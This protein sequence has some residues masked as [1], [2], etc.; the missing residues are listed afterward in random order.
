MGRGP[1][2]KWEWHDLVPKEIRNNVTKQE[3]QRQAIIWELIKGEM[4][5]VK[6]LE[7][8]DTLFIRPLRES[9]IIPPDRLPS[10]LQ[11]VFHNFAE[12]HGHHRRM[13]ERLH[14]IQREEHPFIR[15]ITA[16]VF[17]AAL[18]WRDA[19]L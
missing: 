2:G 6:D 12:I 15:S 10:F 4:V 1:T 16:P 11:D 8:I 18:N 14:E 7:T 9:E 13:L 3:S 5:Y 17:D 19:Y